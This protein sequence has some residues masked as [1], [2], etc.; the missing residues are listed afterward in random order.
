MTTLETTEAGL[1]YGANTGSP[2]HWTD[3]LFQPTTAD[4]HIATDRHSYGERER[5][6]GKQR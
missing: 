2:T 4:S 5:E 3:M 6:R 1:K